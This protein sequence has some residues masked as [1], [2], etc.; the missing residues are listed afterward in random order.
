MT[1]YHMDENRTRR[2]PECG[3]VMARSEAFNG[4]VYTA[5]WECPR[6]DRLRTDAPDEDEDNRLDDITRRYEDGHE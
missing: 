1:R 6:C 5:R 2:C 4:A 3:R